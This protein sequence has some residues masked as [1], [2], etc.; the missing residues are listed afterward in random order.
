MNLPS[1]P[2]CWS[3]VGDAS[4]PLPPIGEA[5]ADEIV[6]TARYEHRRLGLDDFIIPGQSVAK[7]MKE[8]KGN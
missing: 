1:Q 3:P 6:K 8:R 4:P 7:Y 5:Q 2:I